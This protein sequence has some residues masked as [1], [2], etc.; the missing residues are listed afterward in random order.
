MSL[1]VTIDS[2]NFDGELAN[3][4]FKPDN[5]NVTINLGYVTLPFVFDP[6]LLEPQREIYGTYT[7][8]VEK[9]NCTN[10]LNIPRETP[11]PTPTITPT[12]TQTPT[13]TPTQTVTPSKPCGPTP[14]PT[15]T[16]SVTPVPD[17][18]GIY[19]GKLI[20]GVISSGDVSSLT[21]IYTDDPTDNYIT[22]PLGMGYGY[23]LIPI[24]LP[25]PVGFRDSTGGCFG[26]NIPTNNLGQ[27][28]ILD[29]GGFPIT[30]NI[31][32]TFFSINGEVT[33]WLCA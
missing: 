2:V 3:V 13:P 8:L 21:F 29:S 28:I 20:D 17:L 9:G 12:R 1:T 11:T 19:Y 22:Y 5:E 23:V 32:R 30:Y 18:P 33:C 16:P 6:S 4:L 31:Y 24:T 14:T 26:F 15:P 10:I 27:I 25:Q 7:I